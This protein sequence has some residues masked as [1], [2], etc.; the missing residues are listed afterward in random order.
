MSTEMKM[1]VAMYLPNK[2]YHDHNLKS[3]VKKNSENGGKTLMLASDHYFTTQISIFLLLNNS[4]DR[5]SSA[6]GNPL[7]R[8]SL[9]LHTSEKTVGISIGEITFLAKLAYSTILIDGRIQHG[10]KGH[11]PN[12]L[13]YKLHF[14]C[15]DPGNIELG[16][17]NLTFFVFSC[18]F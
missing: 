5:F 3:W 18:Y 10:L 17:P 2:T 7:F 6:L 16:G 13:I 14:G 4:T 1:E 8:M 11:I 12:G 15:S 9:W